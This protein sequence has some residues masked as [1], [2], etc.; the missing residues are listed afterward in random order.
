MA[1]TADKESF[2]ARGFTH[3]VVRK[4]LKTAIAGFTSEEMANSRAEKA[5]ATAKSLGHSGRYI[6]EPVSECT[7]I[8]NN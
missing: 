4:D 5:N 8:A 7:L 2:E 1:H 3:H 6:V